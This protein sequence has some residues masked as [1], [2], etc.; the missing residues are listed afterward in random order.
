MFGTSFGSTLSKLGQV[1][2]EVGASL[3][4]GIQNVALNIGAAIRENIRG[5][6]AGQGEDILGAAAGRRESG[7]AR[8]VGTS[9]NS[10]SSSTITT[11]DSEEVSGYREGLFLFIYAGCNF[12]TVCFVLDLMFWPWKN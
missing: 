3:D 6:G 4:G 8:R 1:A 2:E 12:C 11:P 9:S 10:A 5:S 7:S